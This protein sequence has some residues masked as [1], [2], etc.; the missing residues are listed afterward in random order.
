ML[1]LLAAARP[2]DP[3]V[4]RHLAEFYRTIQDEAGYIRALEARL[5][6]R[7]SQPVCKTLIGLH[8]RAGNY[9]AEQSTI[10]ACRRNG[11]RR[12]DDI[13]R[14]AH[15]V[16]A[17]GDL[18]EAAVL[19][20]TVD[21]RRRLREGQDRHLLFAAL[22][23]TGA[24]DEARR[25]AARWFKGSK[26]DG[27]VLQLIDTLATEN[28][29]DLAIDLAREVGKPG[30]SISLAVA[31]LMLDRDQIVAA[32][33]Y[34]RGWIDAAKL[35]DTDLASRVVR[36]ALEAEDPMLA[37]RAAELHGL[38]RL[39]QEDLVTLAEA[40]SAIDAKAPFQ[41]V[42]ELIAPGLLRQNDLL[43]AAVEV[44]SGKPEPARQLL[45]RVEVKALDEWRLALWA[46]LMTSTGRRA[47]AEQ[48]LRDMAAGS[49]GDRS[50]VL[51]QPPPE[52]PLA[53][54]QP[55]APATASAPAA[56]AAR[57]AVPPRAVRKSRATRNP[58][59]PRRSR[60]RRTPPPAKAPAPALPTPMP[61]PSPG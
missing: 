22:I 48:T 47:T 10:A 5:A 31:E 50:A 30:D 37:Y 59:P 12:P 25:R 27:L 35:G 39:A 18:G 8:R 45:S 44:E 7:Y 3:N 32:R 23:E 4:Q 19:L 13:I 40:L 20:R 57:T 11:Y 33:S 56:E 58:G 17:D 49:A 43:A 34:L 6:S 14:L 38:R 21:D 41:A 51:P 36:A 52:T 42:R 1:E 16:A 46:R 28:R 24:A 61:F 54:D 60:F 15:L 29:H 53:I 2:S 9:A 55:T 26:D